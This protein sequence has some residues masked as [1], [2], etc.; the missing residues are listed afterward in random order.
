MDLI[1]RNARVPE[2][3]NLVDLAIKD[4]VFKRID[5]RLALKGAEEIDAKGNLVSPPFI[6]PHIHLDTV[7]TVGKPRYNLSGT[8]LEGIQ[9]WGAYKEVFLN[10]EDIKKRARRAIEWETT[11]GTLMVRTHVDVCDPHLTALRAILELREA[12]E[13]LIDLQIVAFPQDGI[14]TSPRGPELMEEALR[15]GA[16]L[17]GG[18]P[19]CEWTREDGIRSLDVVFDLAQKYDRSIDVHCDETD[20][21]HSRFLEVVAAKTIRHDY[22][23]RVSASHTTAMHS[24]NNPYAFRLFGLLEQARI[25]IVANPF[26]NIVLQGRFDTYPKRRGITRVK[27]LLERGINVSLG[28]DSIMDPWYP[29]GCG[30]MLQV[31]Q[32]AIHVCHMTGYEEM[33]R[34]FDAVTANSAVTFGNADRYGIVEGKPANLIILDAGSVLEAIRLAPARL[35]VIRAGRVIAR[36][37]A[38]RTQITV[39]GQSKDVSYRLD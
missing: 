23:G 17:V 38:A 5:H 16:D 37:E 2:R 34:M 39:R 21:D 28:H 20:D 15:L 19:H 3:E 12:V 14:M 4:G 8:H 10:P 13:D 36:T 9:V 18:I 29:L 32:M 35:C 26:D 24:Y 11:R 1:V 6:D 7:L 22:Q 27:E 33:H 25:N 31:A 30:D